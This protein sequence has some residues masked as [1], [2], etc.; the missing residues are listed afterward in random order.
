MISIKKIDLS[1]AILTNLVKIQQSEKLTDIKIITGEDKTVFSFH[2]LV[3]ALRSTYFL[4]YFEKYEFQDQSPAEI[5]CK[6]IETETFRYLHNFFYTG[7]CDVNIHNGVKLMKQCYMLQIVDLKE[8]IADYLSQN[9]TDDNVAGFL[10]A[11]LRYK[12]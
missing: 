1:Q 8:Q 7:M 12:E 4:N 6:Q 2:K 9:L 3:L 5:Y 10:N 11:S